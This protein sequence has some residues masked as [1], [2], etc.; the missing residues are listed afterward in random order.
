M[1]VCNYVCMHA[2]SSI[3]RSM[4]RKTCMIKSMFNSAAVIVECSAIENKQSCGRLMRSFGQGV[5]NKGTHPKS[6]RSTCS[7]WIFLCFLVASVWVSSNITKHVYTHTYIYVS[8]CYFFTYVHTHRSIH[9]YMYMYISTCMCIHRYVYIIY[10]YN[11]C[12]CIYICYPPPSCT[13]ALC[14]KCLGSSSCPYKAFQSP[15]FLVIREV[16]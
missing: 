5:V 12:V 7:R 16:H 13:H 8:I 9:V 4:K 1:Y 14:L 15:L 3:K 11:V 6:F 10:I 2:D